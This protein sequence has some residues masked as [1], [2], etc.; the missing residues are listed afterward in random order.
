M[1]YWKDAADAALS[2][3]GHAHHAL[4]QYCATRK[5]V[6]DALVA[7]QLG[8]KQFGSPSAEASREPGP[9]FNDSYSPPHFRI[10]KVCADRLDCHWLHA[11][12]LSAR[13]ALEV[14]K[15]N[16]CV[17]IPRNIASA[18]R[19]TRAPRVLTAKA[20]ADT[21]TQ[22]I[23]CFWQ[24][25]CYLRAL[26]RISLCV[27][28]RQERQERQDISLIEQDLAISMGISDEGIWFL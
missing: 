27:N 10:Q 20:A 2:A 15:A 22:H 1:G 13:A 7:L 14:D 19:K 17:N 28:E 23:V 3:V 6:V 12:F 25:P 16:S 9:C 11:S 4:F 18:L 24:A 5:K 26:R 8:S 21:L